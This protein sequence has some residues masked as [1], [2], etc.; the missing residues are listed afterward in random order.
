MKFPLKFWYKDKWGKKEVSVV[1]SIEN[2]KH[3]IRRRI[4][5]WIFQRIRLDKIKVSQIKR[6][7]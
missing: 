7:P 5:A 2:R 6:C 4:G 3:V 1:K